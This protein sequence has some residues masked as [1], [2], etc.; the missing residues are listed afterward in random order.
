MELTNDYILADLF[1]VISC[2]LED[3]YPIRLLQFDR[4]VSYQVAIRSKQ[5]ARR[6]ALV[7]AQAT[8]KFRIAVFLRSILALCFGFAIAIES[9]LFFCR[10]PSKKRAT[11]FSF[12]QLSVHVYCPFRVARSP[13]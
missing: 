10:A 12:K 13:A 8:Q 6:V 9:N 7:I 5:P 1:N 3:E 2:V 11:Y 4:I